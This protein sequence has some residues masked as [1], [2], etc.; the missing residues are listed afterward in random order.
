L[1]QGQQDAPR[2]ARHPAQEIDVSKIRY[3]VLAP[4]VR[5]LLLPVSTRPVPSGV[6]DPWFQEVERVAGPEEDDAPPT[7]RRAA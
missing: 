5:A 1:L 6:V 3:T 7:Q 2:T 4:L